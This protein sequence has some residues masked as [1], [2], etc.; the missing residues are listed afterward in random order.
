MTQEEIA[1][2]MKVKLASLK[3]FPH[4][5]LGFPPMCRGKDVALTPSFKDAKRVMQ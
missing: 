1:A 3:L 4:Q 5:L 2:L